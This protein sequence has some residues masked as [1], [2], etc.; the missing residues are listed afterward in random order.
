[1][2]CLS[3]Y[4]FVATNSCKI[5]DLSRCSNHAD[6]NSC[7]VVGKKSGRCKIYRCPTV[8][9]KLILFPELEWAFIVFV[10]SQKCDFFNST[11]NKI[12]LHLFLANHFYS[13]SDSFF[14]RITYDT[15]VFVDSAGASQFVSVVTNCLENYCV[16]WSFYDTHV[17]CSGTVSLIVTTEVLYDV[18]SIHTNRKLYFISPNG[19]FTDYGNPTFQFC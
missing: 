2:D 11:S 14:G 8:S 7:P 1:M 19:S 13:T 10:L 4:K 12:F 18:I 6:I 9:I 5:Y 16:G 17:L 15:F 3:Y